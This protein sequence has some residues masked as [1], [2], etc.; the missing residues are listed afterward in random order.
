[1]AFIV[2]RCEPPGYVP[3]HP[4]PSA[5]LVSRARLE[6]EAEARRLVTEAQL[7]SR[8]ILNQAEAQA[9]RARVDGYEAAYRRGEETWVAAALGLAE[10]RQRW[11][12]QRGLDCI[13]LGIEIARQIVGAHISEKPEHFIGMVERICAPLSREGHLTI[14]MSPENLR[15]VETVE[16]HFAES[17]LVE[18]VMDPTLAFGDCIA[19]CGGIRVDGR[20][21]SQ[22]SA[23]ELALASRCSLGEQEGRHIG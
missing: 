5:G 2:R 16:Q 22:L 14:H 10:E 1:M 8:E 18:V 13:R 4:L 9:E 11:I 7:C 20:I 12:D 19:E 6:A 23:I 3:A 21:E 15:A 17:R